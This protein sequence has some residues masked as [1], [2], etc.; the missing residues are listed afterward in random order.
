M[1]SGPHAAPLLGPLAYTT[2]DVLAHKKD[3][4]SAPGPAGEDIF[5]M[6]EAGFGAQQA[7]VF[8]RLGCS[9][10]SAGHV[11][12]GFDTVTAES[13]IAFQC[14]IDL[15]RFDGNDYVSLL[16]LCGGHTKEYHFHERMTCLYDVVPGHSPK[17]AEGAD[18]NKTPIYGYY[19]DTDTLAD[20]DACGA[21]FGVTPDSNGQAVYHHHV[22]EKPPFIVGCYGPSD[23]GTEVSLEE[24]R[25]YYPDQCGDALETV[26][27]KDG[28][29]QVY[30][31]WCPCFNKQGLNDGSPDA[32]ES[33]STPSPTPAPVPMPTPAAQTTAPFAAPTTP[34]P[35]SA[36]RTPAPSLGST[37]APSKATPAPS[38][39]L[40]STSSPASTPAPSKTTPAPS[41]A[42]SPSP[43]K[44]KKKQKK[45]KCTKK[46]KKKCKGK[47][48]KIKKC[49][50]CKRR[51]PR[52][53]RPSARR[54]S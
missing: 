3:T 24:C 29:E 27:L 17:I 16:D 28:T 48:K 20:L 4:S 39:T 36:A 19:E 14:G 26:T 13:M 49:K 10:S 37:P 12:G 52:S 21:H 44:G 1:I 33:A 32:D 2:V 34:A 30:D 6:F 5:G 22:Q 31:P 46:L 51:R 53:N 41:F 11:D 47:K 45:K 18:D 9:D 54:L 15:P 43:S 23:Q 42:P 7:F 8:E 35:S 40:S 50:A 25:S 38:S